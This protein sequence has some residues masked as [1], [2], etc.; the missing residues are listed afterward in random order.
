[1]KSRSVEA[2]PGGVSVAPP[3][4]T[5]TCCLGFT[6]TGVDVILDALDSSARKAC[7]GSL[8]VRELG[9]VVVWSFDGSDFVV[10]SGFVALGELLVPVFDDERLLLERGES[11][12]KPNAASIFFLKGL[13][14]RALFLP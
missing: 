5:V 11:G 8:R 2:T 3:R 13:D 4:F 6:L 9:G 7:L 1:M 10:S 14:L 12:S